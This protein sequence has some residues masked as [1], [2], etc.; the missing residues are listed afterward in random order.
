MIVMR[1]GLQR[2]YN[3]LLFL[4]CV[5]MV[6]CLVAISLNMLTRVIDGWSI[7]GLDGYAGYAIAAALFF[8]L[9]SAFRQGDHIRVTFLLD[10]AKG[11]WYRILSLWSLILGSVMATYIAWFSCRMVWQSHIFHDVAQTGDASPLWIPQLTMAIGTIGFA[12]AV[13]HS[14][15]EA[16]NRSADAPAVAHEAVRTE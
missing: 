8:A 3:T 2:F 1:N 14:L 12:V 11:R 4:S 7:A 9:P 6:G 15:F 13:I 10:R 5:S 16:L